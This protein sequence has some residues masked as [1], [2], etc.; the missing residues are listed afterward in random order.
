MPTNLGDWPLTI[1]V[2]VF[3]YGMF[4][5][6]VRAIKVARDEYSADLSSQRADHQNAMSEQRKQFLETWSTH[7]LE[8]AKELTRLAIITDTME[9]TLAKHTQSHEQLR[10]RLRSR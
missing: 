5:L 3:A 7:M 2:M 6:A 9:K 1:V 4:Q 8:M 10:A